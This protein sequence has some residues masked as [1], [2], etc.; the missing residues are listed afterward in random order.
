MALQLS[1]RAESRVA[2]LVPVPLGWRHFLIGRALDGW[3]LALCAARVALAELIRTLAVGG[4]IVMR[5]GKK[6]C[7]G[8]FLNLSVVHGPLVKVCAFGPC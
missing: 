1:D 2:N 8:N 5:D 7:V 3:S 6:R 4:T